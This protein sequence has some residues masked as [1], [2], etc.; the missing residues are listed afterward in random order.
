VDAERMLSSG[1][2]LVLIWVPILTLW[3]YP[4]A[5][6]LGLRPT[7]LRRMSAGMLLGGVSFIISGLLQGRLDQGQQLSVAWQVL[8]YI[9][10]EAAE[11]MVSATA[12]EFA[13][14]EAPGGMK[15]IIMSCWLMTIALGNFL[16]A[17]FTNL[18]ARFVHARGATEFYFYATLMFLVAVLFIVCARRYRKRHARVWAGTPIGP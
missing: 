1:A 15:S 6:R 11:V 10:L 7:P 13:F 18:N 3:L 8:P 17:A 9:V 14:A 12:L 5:E 2:I 16:V 4:F